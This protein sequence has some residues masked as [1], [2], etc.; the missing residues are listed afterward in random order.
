MKKFIIFLIIT[1]LLAVIAYN[2]GRMMARK[3]FEGDENLSTNT[4][5]QENTENTVS[6][7]DGT[8]PVEESVE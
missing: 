2:I 7:H 5:I 4:A 8:E 1:I 3:V 6:K